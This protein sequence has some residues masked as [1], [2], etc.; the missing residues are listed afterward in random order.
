M[1]KAKDGTDRGRPTVMTPEVLAKIR[2]AYLMD[3]A[4]HEAALFAGISHSAL[5]RYK[6][7][8][9]DFRQEIPTLR[10]AFKVRAKMAIKQ[11]LEEGDDTVARWYLDRRD[12]DYKAK[13]EITS[14]QIDLSSLSEQQLERIANGE[15]IEAVIANPTD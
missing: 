1:P 3:C 10:S 11:S 6:A 14:K 7:A 9:D 8:N 12:P 15:P 4:D 5:A 13:A 2:E